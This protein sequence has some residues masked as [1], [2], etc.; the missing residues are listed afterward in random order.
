M[1]LEQPVAVPHD[2]LHGPRRPPAP[3]VDL[4]DQR[5]VAAA[6]PGPLTACTPSDGCKS[7]S[8][9]WPSWPSSFTSTP[10]C[11]PS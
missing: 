2:H 4:E 10:I 6:R 1:A 11:S 7:T 8:T 9:S 3:V 5:R